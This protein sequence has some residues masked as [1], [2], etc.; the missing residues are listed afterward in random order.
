MQTEKRLMFN[1]IN[2]RA[3]FSASNCRINFDYENFNKNL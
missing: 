2:S 1:L 3:F